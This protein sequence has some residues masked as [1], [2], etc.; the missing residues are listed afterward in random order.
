MIFGLQGELLTTKSAYKENSIL[1]L[2]YF[3]KHS[4]TFSLLYYYNHMLKI[5]RIIQQLLQLLYNAC[6]CYPN[7]LW[8]LSQNKDFIQCQARECHS[9]WK[10][11]RNINAIC[12]I[13]H[14]LSLQSHKMPWNI[15]SF[16]WFLIQYSIKLV[17][18]SLRNQ[19]PTSRITS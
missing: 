13:K 17:N 18:Y 8:N 16:N 11:A 14:F 1:L 5:S 2:H 15:R 7:K 19:Y 6:H 3:L 9:Y 12:N 10:D 4:I